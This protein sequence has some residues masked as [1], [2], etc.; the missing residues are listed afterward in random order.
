M[1]SWS[2]AASIIVAIAAYLLL[3]G[4]LKTYRTYHGVRVITCPENLQPA[5]VAVAAF[6]AAKW[7]A[8]EPSSSSAK[9]KRAAT[10]SRGSRSRSII[11]TR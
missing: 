1:W 9:Q 4:F 11:S 8:V 7:F 3:S 6:D 2:I 5:A 10:S